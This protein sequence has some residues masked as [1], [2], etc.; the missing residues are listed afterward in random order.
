MLGMHT[1]AINDNIEVNGEAVRLY[2][3]SVKF[4]FLSWKIFRKLK[5]QLES[6]MKHTV[7]SKILGTKLIPMLN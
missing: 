7:Y 5:N 3:S 4:L 6:L 1:K 2:I